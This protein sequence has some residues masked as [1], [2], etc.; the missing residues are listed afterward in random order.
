MTSPVFIGID[1]TAGKRPLNYAVLDADLRPLV[2]EGTGTLDELIERVL[3]YPSALVAVDAPQGPNGGLMASADYRAR[4]SPPPAPGRWTG[5]KVCEYLLK[6]RGIGLYNTPSDEAAMPGWMRA[7]LPALRG[8]AGRRLPALPAR[9][10]SARARCWKCTRTLASPSC[11]ATCPRPRP[12]SKAGSSGN[13]C[14]P[15]PGWRCPT[16][17]TRWKSSPL[18]TCWRAIRR[19]PACSHTTRW[20]PWPPY[21][22]YLAGTAP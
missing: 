3:A 5:Y 21:T 20:M 13:W 9:Q 2:L 19:C 15:A 10:H 12:C 22:A 18:I 14:W 4:L 7:G 17:W 6:Q 11:S 8:A 1:P 16:R